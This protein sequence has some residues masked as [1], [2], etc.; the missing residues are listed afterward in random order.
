MQSK[1]NGREFLWQADPAHWPKHSPVLFPIVGKVKENDYS[2][3]GKTY[4]L[5]RH[6]FA[7]EM[8]FSL[9]EQSESKA[10]FQLCSSAESKTVYPFDFDFQ[11][12]YH[13]IQNE[14]HTSYTVKNIGKETLYYNVGAHPAFALPL[15]FTNYNLVFPGDRILTAFEL[16]QELISNS[17]HQIHL[18]NNSLP[19]SYSLFEKDALVF[20]QLESKLVTLLENDK[21]LLQVS[22]ADFPNL[23]I[24]TKP[25]APFICI[26]PWLGFADTVNASGVLQEKEGVQHLTA[27]QQKTVEF[28]TTLFA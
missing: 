3:S 21:P 14:L 18:E 6:G 7:R 12:C 1:A 8:D 24:W 11:I 23:G 27:G 5:P 9:I 28:T 25:Q 26:E 17:T 16:D 10:V 15:D 22:F 13:L 2:H 4:N 20:K 19:L